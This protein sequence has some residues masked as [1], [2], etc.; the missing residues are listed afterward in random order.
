MDIK[1]KL[2]VTLLPSAKDIWLIDKPGYICKKIS[3]RCLVK[4]DMESFK[5][6]LSGLSID[7]S[8]D[9][10][11]LVTNY[12]SSLST[13]LDSYA[14]IK[15]KEIIERPVCKFHNSELGDMKR[16]LRRLE[17]KSNLSG[18]HIDAKIYDNLCADNLCAA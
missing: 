5:H 17:R 3:Y 2:R 10:D 16:E 4:V 6:D 15:I 7:P 9:L 11:D 18:L 8:T 14:P 12:N 13:F 1:D